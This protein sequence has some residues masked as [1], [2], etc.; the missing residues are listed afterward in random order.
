MTAKEEIQDIHWFSWTSVLGPEVNG[1]WPKYTQ[2]SLS[3]EP[4]HNTGYT[5]L[6]E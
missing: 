6:M 1:I 4:V 2:V 5:L 3:S